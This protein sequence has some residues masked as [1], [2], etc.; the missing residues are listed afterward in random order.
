MKID[1]KGLKELGWTIHDPEPLDPI[2][3]SLPI[4]FEQKMSLIWPRMSR[5]LRW[6]I[7][8]MLRRYDRE[9]AKEGTVDAPGWARMNQVATGC[10]RLHQ[11]GSSWSPDDCF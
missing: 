3:T 4:R 10:N 11:D 2:D 7:L 1:S 5:G 6:I 9:I 8:D